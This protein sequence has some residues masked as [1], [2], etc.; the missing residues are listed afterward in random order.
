MASMAGVNKNLTPCLRR[1]VFGRI[2]F[3]VSRKSF[4]WYERLLS[5]ERSCLGW[6]GMGTTVKADVFSAFGR[7]RDGV[8]QEIGARRSE[9]GFRGR[10][11]EMVLA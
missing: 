5:R 7:G 6:R 1:A 8:T 3:D 11:L 9:P 2:R 10:E 4:P